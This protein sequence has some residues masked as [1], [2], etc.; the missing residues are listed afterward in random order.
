[1]S[2]T[3]FP[4]GA[5]VSVGARPARV[6]HHGRDD[7]GVYTRVRFDDGTEE[8]YHRSCIKPHVHA[9]DGSCDC[10]YTQEA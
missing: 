2:D 1:M 7:G 3:R 9:A 4:I 10:H 6:V 8:D 5:L